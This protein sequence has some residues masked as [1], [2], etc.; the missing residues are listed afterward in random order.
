MN[1]TSTD[2]RSNHLTC[3]VLPDLK[4]RLPRSY[5]AFES[6]R[7]G[8]N[9]KSSSAVSASGYPAGHTCSRGKAAFLRQ[10]FP[11][12]Y[13]ENITGQEHSLSSLHGKIVVLSFWATWCAPCREEMPLL[14][15]LQKRYRVHGVQV[16]G[17]SVDDESTQGEIASFSQ[18][19]KINFPI[20]IGATLEH[21]LKA[22]GCG[23]VLPA[24]AVLDRDGQI[25][26]RIIGMG[27]KS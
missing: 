2:L 10:S 1:Q 20:W 23:S 13:L 18:N 11:R 16:I 21:M 9:V 17:A 4:T 12:H 27:Y 22:S 26:G 24:T 7:N 19:L 6:E 3:R 15:S 14:V 8:T 25:V 5:L